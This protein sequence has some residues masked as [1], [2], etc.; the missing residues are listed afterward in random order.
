MSGIDSVLGALSGT[1]RTTAAH[2]FGRNTDIDTNAA[3]TLWPAGAVYTYPSDN[4]ALE[5]DSTSI[6]D[7]ADTGGGSPGTGALTIRVEGLKADY[8]VVSETV[9]MNGQAAVALTNTMWRINSVRV[10]TAGSGGG[11][12]GVVTIQGTGGGTVYAHIPVGEN[13]AQQAVYTVPVNKF[14]WLTRW[15]ARL[16]SEATANTS[17]VVALLI[18]PPGEVFRQEQTRTLLGAG[19]SFEA[20]FDTPL[21]LAEGTDAEVRV[22]STSQND[23]NV[24][25]GFTIINAN[26]D[27]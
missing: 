18:R 22:L 13:K 12:A 9:T 24:T 16:D 10:L 2:Q 7:D 6:Q 17:V 3:E 26:E 21:K 11:N 15:H 25:G 20:V 27:E 23:A 5:A 1:V 8:T 4:V 19:D 14:G